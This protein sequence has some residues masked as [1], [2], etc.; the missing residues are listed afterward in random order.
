MI[1]LK[2]HGGA[3]Q[4]GRSCIE[5]ITNKSRFILDAGLWLTDKG[6]KYP[7]DISNLDEIDAVFISHA[8]LDHIGAL[9]FL[10]HGGLNSRIYCVKGTR[11]MVK[12]LLKDSFKISK[13]NHEVIDYESIDINKVISNFI[14]LDFKQK[15]IVNDITFSFYESGHI[16]GSA[17]ILIE[18]NGK[19]LLY[20]GDI[21]TGETR[22]LNHADLEIEKIDFLITE[23]TYGN[24][25]HPS[26][27]EQEDLM[28]QAVL[29]TIERKG[30]VLIPSFA[31]GRAQ[32]ILLILDDLNLDVPIYLDGMAKQI[33]K[34][35]LNNGFLLKDKDKLE[36]I[37]SKV[38]F[39]ESHKQRMEIINKKEPCVIITT[40]GMVSGGP[41]MFYLEE[42]YNNSK[43]SIILTGY[44]ALNTNGRNISK[45]G[46][47]IINDKKLD[48]LM[49]IYHFDFSAHS[50]LSELK[51]MILKL[52]P[53]KVIVQ[54]GDVDAIQYLSEWIKDNGIEVYHPEINDLLVLDEV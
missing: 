51:N 32:E 50:G 49:K 1:K 8:H 35:M 29:N 44:Q 47:A 4:I 27:I 46:Y 11:D 24:K 54:H 48:L 36:K 45:E 9:P 42:F 18:N 20:T 25:E 21:N 26:R 38:I 17:S 52:E 5:L 43:N 12:V 6:S 10:E 15:K 28:K 30:V 31:I 33:S 34:I 37:I 14:E 13:L 39:V 53:K 3:S 2:F 41:V 16:P 7:T 19:K 40:S 22:L 23:A